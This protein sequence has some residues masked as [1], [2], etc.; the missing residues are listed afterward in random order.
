M[1]DAFALLQ[2]LRLLPLFVRLGIFLLCLLI[3]I[4]VLV[5]TVNL[6]GGH[7]MISILML[8]IAL[9]AWLFSARGT[10]FCLIATYIVGAV[11]ATWMAHSL[12]WPLPITI[13]FTFSSLAMTAEACGVSMLRYA[14]DYARLVKQKELRAEQ[15]LAS[16]LESQ[17]ITIELKD[18][19]FLNMSHELCTPLTELK[20]Y[21]EL[22][23]EHHM[24][25][26]IETR[27]QFLDHIS[28]GCGELEQIV[29]TVLQAAHLDQSLPAAQCET[30]N[31]AS[32]V[33]TVLNDKALHMLPTHAIQMHVPE[34]LTVWTDQK[35]LQQILHN[36]LSNAL[37]YSFPHTA[38][39]ISATLLADQIPSRIPSICIR[40]QDTGPGIPQSDQPLLFRKAVRLRRDVTGSVRGSGLG[41][42][43]SKQFV[44]GLGGRIWVESS[45]VP[46]QGSC[47]CFTLP[48][49]SPAA[50]PSEQYHPA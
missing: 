25:I 12:F 5:L 34:E 22:L 17:R 43:I 48:T 15:E 13:A 39:K 20:G 35:Q 37:K 45:G 6:P 23:R 47:F 21:I 36:L 24:Q 8:P 29:D 2:P 33:H 10:A 42:Y 38:V 7:S 44:E 16:V 41:L 1:C 18:Q 27:T 28:H 14:L 32:V 19:F 26:D 49:A 3:M 9:A 31:I 11:F 30:V 40:V 46:G 4:V 50:I